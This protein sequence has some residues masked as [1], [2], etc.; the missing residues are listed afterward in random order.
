MILVVKSGGE[1][2]LPEWREHF[3]AFAPGL[4]CRW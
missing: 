1:V 4:E 3:A 2:A